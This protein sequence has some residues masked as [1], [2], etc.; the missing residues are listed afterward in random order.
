[1]TMIPQANPCGIIMLTLDI[2]NPFLKGNQPH[3]L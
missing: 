2:S 3:I 1:M